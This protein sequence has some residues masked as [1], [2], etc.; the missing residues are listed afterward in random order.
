M[1]L[2]ELPYAL[3]DLYGPS[4]FEHL[5]GWDDSL[6][7]YNPDFYQFTSIFFSTIGIAIVAFLLFYY[8]IN[9]PR[10]NR[11]WSWLIVLLVSMGLAYGYGFQVVNV[12]IVNNDIA[13]SLASPIGQSNAILFGIYNSVFC[14]LL[15]FILSEA[16]RWWSRNCKHAPWT[17]LPTKLNNGRHE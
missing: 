11:W 1:N 10:F 4:L 17:L 6:M 15:F 7:D 2:F 5:M 3:K 14:G 8:V 13:P 12:D 9:S 16:F